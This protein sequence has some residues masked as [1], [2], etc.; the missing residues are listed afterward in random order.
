[1]KT[2][3]FLLFA[4]LLF[5]GWQSDFLI[6]GASLGALLELPRLVKFRWDLDDTDFNRIWSFC[7]LLNVVLAGYV[8]TN[9]DAGG[10]DGMLHG[11]TVTAAAKSAGLT[12]TRFLRWLPLT[13]FAFV[14][15]QIFNER[16]SVPLTAISLVLRWRRR[17]GDRAFAGRYQDI[18]Y[19]FFFVC[20]FSAGI[21]A[22]TGGQIYFWGQGFLI[23]WA[24]WAVR[25]RRMGIFSW[26]LALAAVFAL[27]FS[28]MAGINRA[29][30][31]IQNFNAQ[32][33]ASF[34][35]QHTD[36]LQSLTSMGRIGR[37]KLSARIVIR[38]EPQRPGDAPP[39]LREA[40][41]R[42][43]GAQNLTWYA[44]GQK[45]FEPLSPETDNTTWILLPEKKPASAVN[46]ACYLNGRSA[47]GDPEGLLPLP[48]GCARLE[49][50]P[51]YM[52][53]KANKNGAVLAAG[54]GLMIFDA[55]HGPGA[56]LD[57]P[58][59]AA[60]TNRFDLGVPTNEIPALQKI[61]SE[62]NL[63]ADA[64]D[65]E[66]RRAVE[67]FF[68]NQFTYRTWQG[69]EKLA[70][71]D[72]SPLTKFLLTSRSGHCE[73]FASATVL[74]LRQMGIPARYAVGYSVHEARG[75]GFVVRER[76]AHAWCLAWNRATKTWDD[77]DTTP[78]SWV[79]IETRRTAGEEWLAD[80]RAWVVFQLAKLRWRQAQLQQYIFWSLIPVMLV[81]LYHI[82]FR[83]RG[84]LRGAKNT[85]KNVASVHLPGL[86]SEFYALEKK[87]AARGVPRQPGEPLAVWLE[88]ALAGP[89][90][91][92]L[93]PPLAELLRLHYAHRFDPAGLTAEQRARL[94]LAAAACLEKIALIRAQQIRP[95]PDP[96]S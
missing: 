43:Y 82:V 77:F 25:S 56:A 72:A 75:S 35:G 65:S 2:P 62:I 50:V 18:S 63:A 64:D 13:T 79:A 28:G 5:W 6:V 76:D 90:L 37:L 24:L 67:K 93:R 96:R 66:K 45:D 60:S 49:N 95:D 74:L 78:A 55:R 3:P 4:A 84:K 29:Q 69:T 94:K 30:G 39:Y 8:F 23:A 7:F 15:A 38:V 27:G 81:L 89:A 58:P 17:H 1:M 53:L 32:W 44:G 57:S 80:L 54:R 11:N 48:G 33:L 31:A 86:D 71:R 21:H 88:R 9:N 51:P 12:T 42:N 26:L 10:L 34:F 59:D 83:R 22:N 68:L 70:T 19:P 36:P 52:I 40:S 73:Y 92:P 61:I 87:L 20:V 46:L 41:Y 14:A 16:P 85:N 91:A 47:D